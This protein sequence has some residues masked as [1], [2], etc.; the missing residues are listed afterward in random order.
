MANLFRLTYKKK[1]EYWALNLALGQ[2]VIK[3][4]K[5]GFTRSGIENYTHLRQFFCLRVLLRDVIYNRF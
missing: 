1:L 5:I 2:A 3:L 4:L